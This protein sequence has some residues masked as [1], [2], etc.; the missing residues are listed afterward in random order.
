MYYIQSV[1]KNRKIIKNVIYDTYTMLCRS[2]KKI[3]KL[4]CTNLCT[5]QKYH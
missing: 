5:F 1:I 2:K 3:K 4:R